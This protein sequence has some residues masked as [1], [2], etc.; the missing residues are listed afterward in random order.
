MREFNDRSGRSWTATI[1]SRDGLDFKGR[2][3]LVFHP[4]DEEEAELPL[5]DV[6]WNSEKTARRTLET[7]SDVELR[8]RLRSAKGRS[9]LP[10]NRGG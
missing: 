4:A 8:R 7:M 1:G 2:Y 10:G 3:Y 6:R 5:E 9:A